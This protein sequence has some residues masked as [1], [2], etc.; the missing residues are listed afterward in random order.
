MYWKI[1]NMLKLNGKLIDIKLGRTYCECQHI[2]EEIQS[3]HTP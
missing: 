3:A 2:I 1:D